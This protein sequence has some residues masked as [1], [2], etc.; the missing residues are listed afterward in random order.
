MKKE[1]IIIIVLVITLF[2]NSCGDFLLNDEYKGGDWF[3]LEN[4][5]A[6]MPVWVRGNTASNIFVIFLHG[7]P[8]YTSMDVA[9]SSAFKNLH[10]E[11]AFVYYDQRGSGAA[12]GNVKSESITVEQFTEDLVKLVHLIRY[13]YDNPTLFLMGH[14]WGGSLGT[15]FLLEP[16]NQQ[17]ISGWIEIN[18]GHNLVDGLLHSEEW[19]IK[20][21]NEKIDSN[22]DS[23]YWRN[24]INW[25]AK[26]VSL[27]KYPNPL[28][29][30]M[31]NI[32]KL[33]GYYLNSSNEPE[34]KNFTSPI[35]PIGFLINSNIVLRNLDLE[36]FNLSPAMHK[37]KTP[38]LVLWGKHDG[39]LPVIM[40]YDAFDNLGTDNTDKYLHIFEY[41]AHNPMFEEPE[42]FV[43]NVKEFIDKYIE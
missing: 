40:A 6:V 10:K 29:R 5:G 38:S 19:V 17:Y 27:F 36:T 39:I 21:A 22:I 7:G 13:K 35:S 8:G 15:A 18:G 24:E 25:Y 9:T 23:T 3:Y 31:E 28:K 11:Y 37:I 41:S 16:E 30:H 43:E 34:I 20:K 26:T 32:Q 14:S 33:N 12:Q 42:I 4:A 2:I 1:R